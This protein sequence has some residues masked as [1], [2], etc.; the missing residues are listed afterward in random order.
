MLRMS[1]RNK[2]LNQRV[3]TQLMLV[4]AE[5]ACYVKNLYTNALYK[6]QRN[7]VI[8]QFAVNAYRK[9]VPSHTNHK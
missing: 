3:L 7:S 9:Q 5:L 2:T 8:P 1:P 4:F 6:M